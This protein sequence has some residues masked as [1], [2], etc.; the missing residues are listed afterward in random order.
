MNHTKEEICLATH[1]RYKAND[2]SNRQNNNIH[3]IQSKLDGFIRQP[4]DR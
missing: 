3:A 4:A 2:K 1:K